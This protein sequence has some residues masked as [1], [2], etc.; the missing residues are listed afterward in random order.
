MNC[1][2][3][4]SE[5]FLYDNFPKNYINK[6]IK[7]LKQ[8]LLFEQEKQLLPASQEI[9][10]YAEHIE[11]VEKSIEEDVKMIYELRM[12]S[13]SLQ[14]ELEKKKN[15]VQNFNRDYTIPTN[16]N[17]SSSSL[18]S[19]KEIN[20]FI[21]QCPCNDCSGYLSTQWKCGMCNVRVCKDCLE[22]KGEDHVCNPDN[23]ATANVIKE[24]TKSCP[25]CGTAI[26]K[27]YGCNHMWCTNCNTGFDWRTR[28][29]VIKNNTN[30]HYYEWLRQNGNN[31][32]ELSD[33]VC[34]GIP[35]ISTLRHIITITNYN[36]N[37]NSLDISKKV[38]EFHRLI[39]HVQHIELRETDEVNNI[40]L[41][42]KLLRKKITIEKFKQLILTRVKIQRN[43]TNKQMIFQTLRDAG[44]DILQRLIEKKE[45][46][47]NSLYYTYIEI[48]NLINYINYAF[49]ILTKK[50]KCSSYCIILRKSRYGNREEYTIEP[51]TAK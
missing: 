49:E 35:N 14:C 21:K 48:Q 6:D 43:K 13:M 4:F 39:N 50:F 5:E 10:K 45:K 19:S 26:G 3:K 32:R 51:Y 11:N 23:I 30:P 46:N 37:D 47:Y 12:K 15:L 17:E 28:K 41:R 38:L 16:Q 33:V 27:I 20:V 2:E 1:H 40:D 9:A 44:S 25:S 7:E 42:V 29:L 36:S 24:S 22:I 34:G 8:N 31:A 18:S